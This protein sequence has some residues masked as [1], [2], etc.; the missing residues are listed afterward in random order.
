MAA[1]EYRR[2]PLPAQ[3][4]TPVVWMALCILGLVFSPFA[5]FAIHGKVAVAG[6]VIGL[7]FAVIPLLGLAAIA[8][9]RWYA[10]RGL[11]PHIAEEWTSGRNR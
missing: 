1:T 11:P 2:T 10:W 4:Q 3:V 6:L 7:W 8:I 9:R 5:G